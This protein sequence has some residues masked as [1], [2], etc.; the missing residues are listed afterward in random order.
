MYM[1]KLECPM[2]APWALALKVGTV[3]DEESENLPRREPEKHVQKSIGSSRETPT[4][5]QYV[6]SHPPAGRAVAREQ[7]HAT[8]T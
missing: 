5:H 2:G 3:L 8:L 6:I 1:Y 4:S 7:H